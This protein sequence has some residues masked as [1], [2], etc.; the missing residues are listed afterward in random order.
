MTDWWVYFI[1]ADIFR[2]QYIIQKNNVNIKNATQHRCSI[3]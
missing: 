1:I 3:F 2:F